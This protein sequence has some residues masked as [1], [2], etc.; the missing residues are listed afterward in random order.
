M[1]REDGEVG[2]S[3]LFED[4]VMMRR[5]WNIGRCDS[6]RAMKLH[7]D[8]DELM[9]SDKVGGRPRPEKEV[10]RT[11]MVVSAILDKKM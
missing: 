8:V 7:T 5:V 1:E 6:R 4:V 3:I 11:L 9:G 10:R 2:E